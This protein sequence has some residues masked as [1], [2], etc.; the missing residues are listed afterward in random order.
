MTN[1]CMKMLRDE[2]NFRRTVSK[3]IKFGHC[4]LKNSYFSI[5]V[6]FF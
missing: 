4:A 3:W 5:R 1:T 6:D 2:A